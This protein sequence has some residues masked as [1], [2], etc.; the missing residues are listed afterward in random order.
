MFERK[1]VITVV[2]NDSDEEA[3][4]DSILTGGGDD[5]RDEGDI[6]VVH[7]TP[8]NLPSVTKSIENGG[9]KIRSSEVLQMPT[10]S[11]TVKGDLVG[12][13]LLLLEALDDHDDVQRVSANFEIEDEKKNIIT[14]N[15]EIRIYNQ[16]AIFT[17]EADIKSSFFTDKFLVMSLLK[18]ED[19]FNV[20]YQNK[21]FMLWI[22]ISISFVAFGGLISFVKKIK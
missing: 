19:Y 3:L 11:V 8:E 5:F 22:W 14:L 10:N 2:K 21:P 7:S 15:P 9:F 16:P 4:L 17:S 12:K 13:A 6:Y 1:G 20:R 18:R